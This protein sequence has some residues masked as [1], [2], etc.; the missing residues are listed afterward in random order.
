MTVDMRSDTFTKPSAAMRRAMA[1]AEVGD[2]VFREDP[3]VNRLEETVARMLG[4]EAGLFVTS[5]TMGNQVAVYT[6]TR[7]GDEV[8]LDADA[9]IFYY[10]AGAP[11]ML[12]S[13]QLRPC[14]GLDG[15]LGAG[16]I[17]PLIRPENI[18][19][20]ITRLICLENTLNRA[21]GRI[22]PLEEIQRIRR[23]ADDYGLRMHLDGARLWNAAVASGDSLAEIAAPFESV[24]V[25]FSKGLGAPVGS[26]LAGDEEFIQ[27]ARRFRKVCGGGMRQAGIIAAGA[28]YAVEHNIERLRVDHERAALLAAGIA[29]LD[30]IEIDMDSVQTNIVF[31]RIVHP[32]KNAQQITA[33][34]AELGVLVLALGDRIRAVMHL[35]LPD[36]GVER[37]VAAFSRVCAS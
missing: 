35:D 27:R 19:F 4:K 2:D 6:H 10:E 21:G 33:E 32:G 13:V 18:H 24:S 29:G 11:A 8:I 9:H 22:F 25:C 28:L 7:P 14:A 30:G 5:G 12:S 20:P 23:L 16:Q 31:I 3:T 17:E 15:I 26:L 36:D 37:A 34:L 1:E